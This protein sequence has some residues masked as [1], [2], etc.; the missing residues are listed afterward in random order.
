MILDLVQD[1]TW[2]VKTSWSPV[3]AGSEYCF[4][5]PFLPGSGRDE[6]QHMVNRTGIKIPSVLK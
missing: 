2:I 3:K 1:L 4:V 5:A 6:C